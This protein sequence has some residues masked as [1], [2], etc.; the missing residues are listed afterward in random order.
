MSFRVART[1][2][3]EIVLPAQV[4]HQLGGVLETLEVV[5]GVVGGTVA[6]EGQHILQPFMLQNIGQPV[7]LCCVE[8][9]AG[10]VHQRLG[11]GVAFHITGQVNGILTVIA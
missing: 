7:H 4:L 3:A 10:E 6:A 1:R 11:G 9:P 8:C 2:Q 5:A